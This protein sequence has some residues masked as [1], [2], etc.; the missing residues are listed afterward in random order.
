MIEEIKKGKMVHLRNTGMT[1]SQI[2]RTVGV[3]RDEVADFFHHRKL[4]SKVK[5]YCFVL[6]LFFIIFGFVTFSIYSAYVKA[7][8]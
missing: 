8:Q 4:W 3:S 2:G 1:F 5:R 6:L 7:H